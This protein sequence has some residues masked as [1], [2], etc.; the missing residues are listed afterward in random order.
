MHPYSYARR[1]EF[2][3]EDTIN[4]PE[5]LRN[6]TA[7]PNLFPTCHHLPH[8]TVC[9]A[10]DGLPAS[11]QHLFPPCSDAYARRAPLR[12]RVRPRTVRQQQQPAASFHFHGCAPSLEALDRLHRH[13]TRARVL[14]C[15]PSQCA[16]VDDVVARRVLTFDRVRARPFDRYLVVDREEISM[17]QDLRSR[18]RSETGSWWQYGPMEWFERKPRGVDQETIDGELLEPWQPT[19]EPDRCGWQMN[20]PKVHVRSATV[21]EG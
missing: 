4:T 12:K 20:R 14:S 1:F 6:W 3:S 18:S 5:R 15:A 16:K 17:E 2:Y 11:A 19:R 21:V 7:G 8:S 9:G 13:S 10:S